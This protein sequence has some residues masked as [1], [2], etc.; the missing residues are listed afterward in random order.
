[1]QNKLNIHC[2]QHVSFEDLGCIE[3]WI[4][5]H[6]HS[7]SYTN[8]FDNPK[9]PDLDNIDALIILGG[10]MSVHE[11]S[12]FTWLKA[13]KEFIKSAIDQHKKII[14]ICL[15][16]QLISNVLGGNITSN[17]QNEIGWFP[18]SI[19]DSNVE[20]LK[21]FPKSFSVFHWHG[22]T[23]SIPED[24]IR[25][26]E[27]RACVN[28]AFLLGNHVLGLQFHLEVTLETMTK[29]AFHEQ[30]ELVKDAYVQTYDEIVNNTTFLEDNNQ[31]MFRLLDYLFDKE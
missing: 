15:G 13:E 27:S 10:P 6:G 28:Q 11:E 1:M 12:E 4:Q 21:G 14:G 7:L 9:F 24:A 5:D 16:A 2:L 22:E 30:S 3:N 8:L 31:M 17:P 23:F 25:L 20:M 29:M 19:V 26:M 18:V